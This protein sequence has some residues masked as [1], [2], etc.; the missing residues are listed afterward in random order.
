ML[1]DF[2]YLI[3]RF[4][5]FSQIAA[6]GTGLTSRQHQALLA[7]KGFP[8]DGSPTMGE[9]AERLRIQPHSAAELA[10]LCGRSMACK[11]CFTVHG[12]CSSCPAEPP[13]IGH[14]HSVSAAYRR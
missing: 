9:L 5:E 3:R 7:I 10:A 6:H 2:R 12:D 14:A 11:R 8:S 1:S 13:S 4:L